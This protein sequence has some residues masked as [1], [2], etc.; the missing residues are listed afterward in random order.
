ML[1]NFC[2][3]FPFACQSSL[4]QREELGAQSKNLVLGIEGMYF[5]F[6]LSSPRFFVRV[7]IIVKGAYVC[8]C[9]FSSIQVLTFHHAAGYIEGCIERSIS[10]SQVANLNGSLSFFFY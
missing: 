2:F 7:Q 8:F 3:Q 10:V 9:M 1:D 4:Q 6:Y 5:I